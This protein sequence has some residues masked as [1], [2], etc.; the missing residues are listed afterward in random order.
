VE[1]WVGENIL[2]AGPEIWDEND[3]WWDVGWL[4]R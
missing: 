2:I 3:E 4:C 1:W